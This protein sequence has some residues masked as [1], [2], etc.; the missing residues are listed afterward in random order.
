MQVDEGAPLLGD[1]TLLISLLG[2]RPKREVRLSA[3]R[4][5][6]LHGYAQPFAQRLW[7]GV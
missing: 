2:E 4:R 1:P 5:R 3:D 6:D 7:I